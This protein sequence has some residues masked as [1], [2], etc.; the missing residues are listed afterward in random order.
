M[1]LNSQ[2]GVIQPGLWDHAAITISIKIAERNIPNNK[3][4]RFRK[5][6]DIGLHLFDNGIEAIDWSFVK[7]EHSNS[8]ETV[9]AFFNKITH[10][11]DKVFLL[12]TYNIN[13]SRYNESLGKIRENLSL[14]R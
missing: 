9:S 2:L 5:I 10:T 3:T 8:Y 11:I 6:T 12:I 7:Q 14:V 4:I 1:I 13:I